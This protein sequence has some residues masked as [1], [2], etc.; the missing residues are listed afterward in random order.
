M[1][2]IQLNGVSR[3]YKSSGGVVTPALSNIDLE[4]S[5]GEFVAVVG[6]S[7][8]GKSTLMNVLG[9][10]D[11]NF[12][13]S[14]DLSGVDVRQL[15]DNDLSELRIEKIGFVFQQFHLLRRATI[16]ENVLL[17]TAYRKI[18][19]AKS[20]AL[21]LIDRIGL[22]AHIDHKSNQLSGGQM[23]RVAIARALLTQPQFILADEPTGNLD[24]AT[25]AEI[26]AIFNELNSAGSTIMLITHED[27]IAR[28][29]QRTVRLHDGSIAA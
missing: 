4:I 8:S 15:S 11:R 3:S 26:M 13:G 23:Q 1:S 10:L 18:P 17:P 2:V 9:L 24:G 5:G 21:E 7:G 25:A 27:E 6:S 28:H 22:A 16:L 20:R 12:E 29:A 19:N 14:Y